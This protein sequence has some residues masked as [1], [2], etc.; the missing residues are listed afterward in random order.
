MTAR[1]DFN[2]KPSAGAKT[3]KLYVLVQGAGTHLQL[4]G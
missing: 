4:T 3:V 1:V 2:L